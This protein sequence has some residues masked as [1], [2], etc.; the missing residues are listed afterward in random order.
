MMKVSFEG[1]SRVV[2][3]IS[4][5]DAIV[6]LRQN[7]K[8]FISQT[9][10]ALDWIEIGNRTVQIEADGSNLFALTQ[11]NEI[12]AYEGQPGDMQIVLVPM[13]TIVGKTTVIT[14]IPTLGGREVAFEKTK[15]GNVRTFIKEERTEHL[16][17]TQRD[18]T[19]LRLIPES[20]SESNP[21]GIFVELHGD[22]C[23]NL[24]GQ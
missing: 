10:K 21:Y 22:E 9:D 1:G 4:Y 13:T 16:I 7:G 18:G 11:K 17:I 23:H 6:A 20:I 24:L 2:E 19:R 8:I 14:L 15:I 5:K 12:W 3:M